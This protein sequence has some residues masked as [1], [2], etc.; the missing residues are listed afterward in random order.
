VIAKT[1]TR[2]LALGLAVIGVALLAA[3][4][5]PRW[6]R[7]LVGL[8]DKQLLVAS[9]LVGFTAGLSLALLQAAYRLWRLPPGMHPFTGVPPSE[10]KTWRRRSMQ[11]IM[12]ARAG[13][14]GEGHALLLT[15]LRRVEALSASGEP[16]VDESIRL[17]QKT[18][19]RYVSRHGTG[20]S[21]PPSAA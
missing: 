17:Y 3:G 1:K 6:G 8:S 13:R 7:A 5:D 19:E 16:W 4:L 2:A 15:A 12:M 10:Y 20:Q 14:V 11:A 18:L 9:L 21:P